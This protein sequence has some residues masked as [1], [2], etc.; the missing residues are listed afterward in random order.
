[1]NFIHRL[2][3]KQAELGQD[4]ITR[5]LLRHHRENCGI[6]TLE[7]ATAA[8]YYVLFSGVCIGDLAPTIL[9]TGRLSLTAQVLR[10]DPN[11]H[12]KVDDI[13]GTDYRKFA[14][15]SYKECAETQAP[16]LDLVS[17]EIWTGQATER[18]VYE[19]IILP[20][21]RKVPHLL[22]YSSLLERRVVRSEQDRA[23]E[24]SDYPQ[25]ISLSMKN[26][27][28]AASSI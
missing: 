20:Y 13:I 11:R 25:A 4:E 27:P 24:T 26:S 21:R 7:L 22:T 3:L 8:P 19:R 18:V 1:M 14:A 16:I 28:P 5:F 17:A 10:L 9:M 12:E 23:S 15:E 6:E 2:G